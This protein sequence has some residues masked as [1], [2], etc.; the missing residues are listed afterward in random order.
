MT[1]LA[2]LRMSH[3]STCQVVMQLKQNDSALD[4]ND[5]LVRVEVLTSWL[6]R[7]ITV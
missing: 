7:H 5:A 2:H 6:H 4:F 3:S 1:Q